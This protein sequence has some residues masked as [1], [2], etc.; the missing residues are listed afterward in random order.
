M[1]R[2]LM[3]SSFWVTWL[4]L[5]CELQLDLAERRWR[6]VQGLPALWRPVCVGQ[7]D[8]FGGKV[9]QRDLEHVDADVDLSCAEQRA[10][11]LRGH[12]E[13]SEEDENIFMYSDVFDFV[14]KFLR[15]ERHSY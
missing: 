11:R 3:F 15:T 14:K 10:R 6:C 4:T 2:W 9:L 8:V 13:F 1:I 7:S 12:G 5:H